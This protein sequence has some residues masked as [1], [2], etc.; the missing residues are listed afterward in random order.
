M[1]SNAAGGLS[2]GASRAGGLITRSGLRHAKT[3]QPC[4]RGPCVRRTPRRPDG[5]VALH[6]FAEDVQPADACWRWLTAPIL[7][8]A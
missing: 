1:K 5:V 8:S 7:G 6:L 3:C 2:V 4:I